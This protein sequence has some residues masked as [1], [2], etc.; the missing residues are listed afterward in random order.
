MATGAPSYTERE[1]PPETQMCDGQG[2]KVTCL[3]NSDL[4]IKEANVK[5]PGMDTGD[6]I[7]N[8]THFNTAV[9]TYCPPTLRDNTDM[10]ITGP[11]APHLLE[12]L[13]S[14]IGT[15]TT[16]SV[17]LPDGV[18]QFACY[19]ALRTFEPGEFVEATLPEVT[20]TITLTNTDDD[21]AEQDTTITSAPGT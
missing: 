7:N 6:F 12:D 8:T 2:A 15:N 4:S 13:A 10:V 1:T 11:W 14:V 21:G 9:R 17:L 3:L 20:L 18:S 16:W 19:G 5:M